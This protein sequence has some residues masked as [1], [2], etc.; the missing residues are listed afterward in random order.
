MSNFH[1]SKEPPD[2]SLV[3]GVPLILTMIPLEDLITKLLG[4]VF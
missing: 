2:F 3:P 4:A 1:K